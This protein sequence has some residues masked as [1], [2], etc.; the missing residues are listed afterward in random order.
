MTQ[1]EIDRL[2]GRIS[3]LLDEKRYRE[4]MLQCYYLIQ[5]NADATL[6]ERL[7][8][9]EN[10]YRN[11]LHYRLEGVQDPQQ[12]SILQR[13]QGDVLLIADY[14]YLHWCQGFSSRWTYAQWRY[15]RMNPQGRRSLNDI[16]KTIADS[17]DELPLLDPQKNPQTK[18]RRR[19]LMRQISDAETAFFYDILLSEPWHSADLESHRK[20]FG[21]LTT[22]G[23]AIAVSALLLSLQALFDKYKLSFLME[24]CQYPQDIVAM[25]SLA[26]LL[27]ILLQHHRRVQANPA[28]AAQLSLLLGQDQMPARVAEVC[29]QLIRA[30]YNDQLLNRMEKELLPGMNKLGDSLKDK[31]SRQQSLN[32]D[33]DDL[34]EILA[35]ED[36]NESMHEISDLQSDGEDVYM[37]T[38]SHLKTYA[39]FNELAH[40]FAPFWLEHPDLVTDIDDTA[41]D[42]LRHMQQLADTMLLCDSDKYSFCINLFRVPA[43]YRLPM[44]TNLNADSEQF[45][46]I[47]EMERNGN[48]HLAKEYLSNLYIQDLYRFYKLFPSKN[49][50]YNPFDAEMDFFSVSGLDEVLAGEASQ[51]KIA[52]MLL[53]RQQFA[54]AGQVYDRLL[55]A[56]ARNVDYRSSLAWCLEKQGQYAAAGAHYEQLV[57]QGDN[58]EWALRRLAHCYK[59]QGNYGKALGI[60]QQLVAQHTDNQQYLLSLAHCQLQLDNY[61]AA[62]NTYYK[63][64]FL[65][66]ESSKTWRPLAWCLLMK[67]QYQQSEKIYEKLLADKP[68]YADYLSYG[69]LQAAQGKYRLAVDAYEKSYI[70]SGLSLQEFYKNFEK[71]L[72]QMPVLG[73]DAT[74]L[75]LLADALR[76]RLEDSPYKAEQHE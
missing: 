64:D 45:K 19:Q 8:N 16:V 56:S 72:Q 33:A 54:A 29:V 3:A 61:D 43:E 46:E 62:L 1:N 42:T 28:L 73:L 49:D 4:A 26:A 12:E 14:A 48:K 59:Q 58:T 21:A 60:Y 40:W 37:T 68:D 75:A 5:Q 20:C 6:Q 47:L 74:Q 67:G 9:Q 55:H 27:L 32:L 66:G 41:T 35:D 53:N 34:N 57:A 18:P 30:K 76:Y 51:N 23:R 70:T 31:M 13:L 7:E 69:H 25:R 71:D 36:F 38:F 24:L 15:R 39:F 10:I 63:M 22:N 52:S 65:F 11:L 17:L 44:L 2:Y 50:F